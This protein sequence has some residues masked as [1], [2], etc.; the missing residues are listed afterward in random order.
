MEITNKINLC[1]GAFLLKQKLFHFSK[2]KKKSVL[3]LCW[4]YKLQY[5]ETLATSTNL[6][7][8]YG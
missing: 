3:Y 7:F 2:K 4:R 8:S 1:E 5:F 6:L